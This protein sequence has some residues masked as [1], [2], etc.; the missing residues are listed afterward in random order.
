MK[1][2]RTGKVKQVYEVDEETLEFVFTDNISVFDKIIPTSIPVQGR[3][4]VP[5]RGLLVPVAAARTA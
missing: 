3:D 4:P 5:R 1:L 2:I